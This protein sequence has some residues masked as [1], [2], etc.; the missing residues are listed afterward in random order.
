VWVLETTEYILVWFTFLA[1]AWILKQEGHVKVEILVSR[2]NPRVQALLGIITSIIGVVLCS[3]LIV[4]GSQVVWDFSQRN[5]LMDSLLEPPKAPLLA[6]IPIGSFFLLIQFL[7]RSYGYLE[8]WKAL[9]GKAT[10]DLK[11]T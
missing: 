11:T 1:A 10:R 4:Y 3:L 6:I 7:R 8:S 9:S 5:L 2:L